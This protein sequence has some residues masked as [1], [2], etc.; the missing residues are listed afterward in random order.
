MKWKR[1]LIVAAGIFTL[2]LAGVPG[3]LRAQDTQEPATLIAIKINTAEFLGRYNYEASISA[4]CAFL[5]KEINPRCP[6]QRAE[7][8][9]NVANVRAEIDEYSRALVVESPVDEK[10]IRQRL[11]Y[12]GASVK[13]RRF[14]QAP[15]GSSLK[16]EDTML[17]AKP[18][19]YSENADLLNQLAVN[20]NDLG[21]VCRAEAAG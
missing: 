20:I 12:R 10:V 15:E 6:D 17:S 9:F 4:T 18:L 21:E 14:C 11:Y 13:D 19:F 8:S 16:S 3:L 2:F 5:L 7:I 1:A